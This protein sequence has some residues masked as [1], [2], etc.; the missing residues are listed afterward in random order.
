MVRVMI[1]AHTLIAQSIACNCVARAAATEDLDTDLLTMCD[2]HVE[3][4]STD[5][6]EYWGTT[7][8]GEEWRVHTVGG[9]NR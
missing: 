4:A 2:D 9:V 8:A 6:T 3:N 1:N 5:E 7:D